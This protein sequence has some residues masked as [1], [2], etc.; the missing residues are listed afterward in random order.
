MASRGFGGTRPGGAPTFGGGMTAG[1]GGG[2]IPGVAPISGGD[3]PGVTSH[4]GGGSAPAPAAAP[5][6]APALPNTAARDPEMSAFMQQMRGR[7]ATST[8]RETG[9]DPHLQT[10]INRL[11]DRLSG[12][13]RQRAQ[14]FASQDIGARA[15]A[16][17]AGMREDLARR[18]IRGDSGVAAELS[19]RT[20]DK[21]MQESARSAAGIALGREAQ[22]DQLVLGGQGIMAAPGQM[23]RAREGMTN[24]L[25]STG[26]DQ[27]GAIAGQNL[28][29]RG[30]G[31][32]QWQ[33]Q[34]NFN[35]GA[36]NL[37]QSGR[38]NEI[39]RLMALTRM[40]GY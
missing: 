9:T 16:S 35:L 24:Q 14:D 26:F 38:D 34:G 22:L 15:R 40:G 29:D 8:G 12:D 25:M 18:G 19:Q 28:A 5:V 6:Q 11:G 33:A 2:S 39:A 27:A 32:N 7:I 31:L 1:G 37:A 23:A 36:A 4:G 21:A 30:L 10:Q 17:E 3:I 13:P 20:R